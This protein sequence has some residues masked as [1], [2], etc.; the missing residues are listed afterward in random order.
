MMH[1]LQQIASKMLALALLGGVCL[2]AYALVIEP[3]TS[4]YFDVREQIAQQRQ[5][6]GRLTVAASQDGQA[7]DIEKRANAR[8]SGAVYLPGSSDGV[9]IAELQSLLGRITEAEGVA[10]KSSR[11]MPT[12]D[13][14]GLRML[15][16]EVQ[17]SA[18]IEQLQRILYA[19]ETGKPYL[20]VETLQVTPP[21]TY[22][23][24]EPKSESL[25]EV[26]VGLSGLASGKKG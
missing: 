15:G 23:G 21:A 25:L 1:Q 13:R 14:D 19:V 22:A 18:N 2:V 11:A 24:S 17:M 6:L 4:R 10:I 7:K 12:H 9:R 16:I 8:A 20:F 5:L 3:L 26:R